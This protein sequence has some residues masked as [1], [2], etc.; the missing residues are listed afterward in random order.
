[1][2]REFALFAPEVSDWLNTVGRQMDGKFMRPRLVAA[3]YF[4]TGGSSEAVCVALATAVQLLHVGLC[5]HDDLIDG[6][7]RRHGRLNV[8][9]GERKRAADAG[10]SA[11]TA[12]R[13]ARAAALLAGDLCISLA[14]RTL[15]R[16]EVDA[17]V[18]LELLHALD[19]ALRSTIIGE[20]LDVVSEAISPELSRPLDI[21]VLKTASYSFVL[22]LRVGAIAG[23]CAD[24]ELLASLERSG[25]RL[26]VAYQLADDELGVFGDAA[27]T[28]KSTLSDLRGG[29]RTELVRVAYTRATS[30]QRAHLDADLGRWT[31]DEAEAAPLRALIEKTGA[32]EANRLLAQSSASEAFDE[33]QR[34]RLPRELADYLETLARAAMPGEGESGT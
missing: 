31:L 23:A 20:Y 17:A 19:D 15:M 28:G 25:R 1:V 27:E 12:D 30:S 8:V 21:A 29:K 10:H 34:S 6:D 16:A 3:A 24:G 5:I 11:D 9:G 33:L 32:R 14:H 22:P 4:G 2:E 7:E 26:G 18:R 13:R